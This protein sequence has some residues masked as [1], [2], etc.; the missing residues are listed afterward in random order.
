[1]SYQLAHSA[2]SVTV[3]TNALP[4]GAATIT[5][6]PLV[7]NKAIGPSVVA[8][9][10]PGVDSYFITADIV[11]P[12]PDSVRITSSYGATVTAPVTTIR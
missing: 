6:T 3:S 12:L 10:N 5:I 8:A 11:N 7:N 2:L 9:Y 1:V 4:K